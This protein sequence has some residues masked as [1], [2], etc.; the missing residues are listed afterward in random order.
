MFATIELF[1]SGKATE[2]TMGFLEEVK[3]ED[4]LYGWPSITFR[5]WPF[6][7]VNIKLK[8]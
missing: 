8:E 5:L 1:L 6:Y 7:P 2:L 4:I 3:K